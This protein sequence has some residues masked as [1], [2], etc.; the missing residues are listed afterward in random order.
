[1]PSKAFGG[2][3]QS[4]SFRA[5]GRLW[6]WRGPLAPGFWH[7][8]GYS[9]LWSCSD[10]WGGAQSSGGCG[11]KMCFRPFFSRTKTPL[12]VQ[13]EVYE[14]F[15]GKYEAFSV[16]VPQKCTIGSIKL[17]LRFLKHSKFVRSYLISPPGWWSKMFFPSPTRE[18]LLFRHSWW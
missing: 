16:N 18:R 10:G 14:T 11:G 15:S 5:V 12:V 3:G 6:R 2:V 9:N 17:H 1:M 7:F 8:L 4:P 13:C